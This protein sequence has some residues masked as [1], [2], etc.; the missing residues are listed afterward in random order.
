[1][2]TEVQPNQLHKHLDSTTAGTITEMFF[3]LQCRVFSTNMHVVGLC[4][5]QLISVR[6]SAQVFIANQSHKCSVRSVARTCARNARRRACKSDSE[7]PAARMSRVLKLK[8]KPRDFAA[9]PI[10][11]R[12]EFVKA[13]CKHAFRR[14]KKYRTSRNTPAP[15]LLHVVFRRL[16]ICQCM[17]K[18]LCFSC[19]IVC[20]PGH[21][22]V[23]QGLRAEQAGGKP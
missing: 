16:D 1:M 13:T 22:C 14:Q 23:S 12:G 3:R 9:A 21:T 15:Q 11:S 5:S 19:V 8:G 17:L 2:K 10:R 20:A 4:W 18:Q 7:T 6:S